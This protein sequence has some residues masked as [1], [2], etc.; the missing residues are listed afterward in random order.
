M[1]FETPIFL[2]DWV[3]NAGQ[4]K[5]DEVV[6]LAKAGFSADDVDGAPNE[7]VPDEI[8]NRIAQEIDY[9][10]RMLGGLGDSLTDDPYVT[11][12]HGVELQDL[13]VAMQIL[14]HLSRL[15]VA[16]DRQASIAAIGMAE[17]RRRLT[18]KTL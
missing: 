11:A 14:G 8:L 9:V 17:L 4:Q 13:D 12:R 10:A 16:P 2:G 18:R 1:H 15:I 7:F 3:P 6:A 5:V